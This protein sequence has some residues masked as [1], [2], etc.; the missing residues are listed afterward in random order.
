MYNFTNT[1]STKGHQ[2]KQMKKIALILEGKTAQDFL[3]QLLEQYHSSHYYTIITKDEKLIPSSHPN[4]FTF[5]CFDAT[6]PSKL[7]NAL[8]GEFDRIFVIHQNAEERK[9][10]YTLLRDTFPKTLIIL[11]GTNS[12]GVED[13]FLQEVSIPLVIS[14]KLINYLPDSPHTLQD[15][16]LGEG[17]IMEILVPSGSV[18]CYRQLGSISQKEWRIAGIYRQNQLL[19]SNYA[20]T[21]QP[22]DRLLA[23][24]NPKI[25]GN[26]YRQ[27]TSSLGQFPIPFGKDLFLYLDEEILD[28]N[29]ILKDLDDALLLHQKLNSNHLY[30]TLLNPKNFELLS[31]LKSIQSLD[32]HLHID[33]QKRSFEEILNSDKAKRIGLAILN[34]KFF[35][36][37]KK[38]LFELFIPIYKSG[39]TPLCECKDALTL[40]GEE[41]VENIASVTLDISSQLELNFEMYDYDVDGNYHIESF[42]NFKTLSQVFNKPIHLTQSSTKNPILFLQ[43]KPKPLLQFIPFSPSIIKSTLGKF[44][45]TDLAR[46]S[47]DLELYPQILIPLPYENA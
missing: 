35:N 21:I 33:Y 20:L 25:L 29:E 37:Y 28:E 34:H 15:F 22:N 31:H 46:Y 16:G 23:I 10:I 14:N 7:F 4:N 6:S 40:L 1:I 18:Y 12:L 26:I 36:Q 19:L 45:S 41:K 38:T 9:V 5:H 3:T 32:I 11:S 43:E 39:Q 17:E 13:K 8:K 30:I 2:A 42:E 24:G 27:V 47:A 44:A